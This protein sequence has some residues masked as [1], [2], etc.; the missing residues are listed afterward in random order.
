METATDI[1]R[2]LQLCVRDDEMDALALDHY[3]FLF[4]A[5]LHNLWPHLCLSSIFREINKN[6]HQRFSVDGNTIFLILA[7]MD[8]LYHISSAE[9][10]RYSQRNTSKH[11][12]IHWMFE[13]W[14]LSEQSEKHRNRKTCVPKINV[15]MEEANA[16]SV[17]IL[18]SQIE[19]TEIYHMFCGCLFL[20]TDLPFFPCTSVIIF[21]LNDRRMRRDVC[22]AMSV[23][24]KVE[25]N[26]WQKNSH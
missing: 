26:L 19:P 25:L 18:T 5:L 1:V 6:R 10:S 23:H 24:R 3:T 22:I 7:L 13:L 20:S 14:K 4:P 15:R 16:K 2:K 9:G 17:N 11:N 8:F 12:I 21:I